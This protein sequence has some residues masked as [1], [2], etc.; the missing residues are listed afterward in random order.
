[1]LNKKRYLFYFQQKNKSFTLLVAIILEPMASQRQKFI[2]ICTKESLLDFNLFSENKN[3][4]SLKHTK[5][6]IINHMFYYR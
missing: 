1:M 5:K 4:N 6:H 3:I 2:A